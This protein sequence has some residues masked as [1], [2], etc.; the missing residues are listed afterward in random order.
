MMKSMTGYGRVSRSTSIGAVQLE[1]KCVNSK[2]CDISFRLPKVLNHLEIPI[3][4]ILQEKLL[5]GKVEA[6]LDIR[7]LKPLQIPALN[8]TQFISYLNLLDQMKRL[9]GLQDAVSL[10]HILSFSELIEYES[11]PVLPESERELLQIAEEAADA[12]DDMR[13]SEGKHL[14]DT[15]RAQ[16]ARLN[17][18]MLAIEEAA[19]QVFSYWFERFKNK[20]AEFLPNRVDL[21]DRI[22]QEAALFAEKA[23]IKEEIARTA[24]HC[25]QFLSIMKNEYPCG[26]KL[27]FLCQELY[28]EFNTIAS[29]SQKAEIIGSVIEAKSIVD[30]IREQ[31]QN[32][33]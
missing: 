18:I 3:K 5:R 2:Y 31:L 13:K 28:R 6:V 20:I 26:K 23:D 19:S 17:E 33:V 1:I 16:L 29:K 25:K 14:E 22:V 11:E 27:D 24:S 12:L 15:I 32:I 30:G 4:G 10:S 7:F 9:G 8:R 21:E